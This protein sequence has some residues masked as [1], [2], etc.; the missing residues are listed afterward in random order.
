ME[1]ENAVET[2]LASWLNTGTEFNPDLNLFKHPEF[3]FRKSGEW[4]GW[5][6][7]LNVDEGADS[8]GEHEQQDL[9]DDLA[10]QLYISRFHS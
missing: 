4:Q 5:N 10:W 3:V 2:L 8:Y 9:I 1:N 6:S 7:F